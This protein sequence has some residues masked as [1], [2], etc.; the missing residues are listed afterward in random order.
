MTLK[1]RFMMSYKLPRLTLHSLV[2]V[3]LLYSIICLLCD[4]LY[5]LSSLLHCNEDITNSFNFG[6]NS[7]WSPC[8]VTRSVPIQSF[9]FLDLDLERWKSVREPFEEWRHG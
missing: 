6:T 5:P 3:F 4:V 9:L 7:F 1:A 8:S 2:H